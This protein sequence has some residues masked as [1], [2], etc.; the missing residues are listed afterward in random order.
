ML[1]TDVRL[2]IIAREARVKTPHVYHVWA[3]M[4]ANKS[5]FHIDAFAEFA[6]LERRHVESIIAALKSH[7]AMPAPAKRET[8]SGTRLGADFAMPDDWIN[9]AIGERGWKLADARQE[10]L[11]FVDYWAAC[12]GAKGVKSDW[13]ATWRNW[14]RRSDRVGTAKVEPSKLTPLEIAERE[15]GAAIMLGQSYEESVARKK[16]A[17]I[18]PQALRLQAVKKH[19]CQLTPCDF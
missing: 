14:C 8:V 19:S 10:A 11:A 13:L 3:A 7:N 6:G 17:A 2:T 4:Q 18:R 12:S 15:L 9:W 1:P 16:I 5:A